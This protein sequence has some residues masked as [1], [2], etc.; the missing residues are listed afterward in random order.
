[1]FFIGAGILGLGNFISPT[2]S[3]HFSATFLNHLDT[4]LS[5]CLAICFAPCFTLN[6]P[7]RSNHIS[8]GTNNASNLLASLGFSVA[9]LLYAS[10]H[11]HNA[12]IPICHTFVSH[13]SFSIL[14]H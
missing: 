6:Q 13:N 10:I 7:T 12:S 11:C 5:D 14:V 2:L 4:A 3:S 8:A 9:Q 1:M